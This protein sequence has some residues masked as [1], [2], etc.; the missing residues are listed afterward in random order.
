MESGDVREEPKGKVPSSAQRG[1]KKEG[2]NTM[3][4]PSGLVH[5]RHSTQGEMVTMEPEEWAEESWIPGNTTGKKKSLD[6]MQSGED[7]LQL[8]ASL[9]SCPFQTGIRKGLPC[10][11]EPS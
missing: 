4:H 10:S 8:F 11:A 9:D 6:S 2:L 3:G 5:P 7:P 1:E